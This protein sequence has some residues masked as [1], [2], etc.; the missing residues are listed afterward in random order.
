MDQI[1]I[2]AAVLF[3]GLASGLVGIHIAPSL[4][5]LD[6][7]G[8]RRQHTGHIPRVGGL[9]LC[10]AV[11]LL[12]LF[13]LFRLPLTPLELCAVASMAILGFMDDRLE[14]RARWKAIL[15]LTVALVLAGATLHHLPFPV[16]SLN[17]LGFAVPGHPWV[18]FGLLAVM[19]WCLPHAF[20]LIDGA[21]GLATGFGL[22][23]LCSLWAKG[24]PHPVAVGGLLACLALNWPKAKLF[25]GD[26]GSLSIGL[27][28]VIFAQ[29]ALLMPEPNHIM[30]LFAYPTVDVLTVT[31]IR[32]FSKKPIMQGDRNHLHYQIADRWPALAPTAVPLLLAISA[33]CGSEVYLPAPWVAVP[34]LGLFAL[35][36]LAA[37][38]TVTSVF[39]VAKAEAEV[40][41]EDPRPARA[42]I[43]PD[44]SHLEP[45]LIPRDPRWRNHVTN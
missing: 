39:G 17:L 40:A 37:F 38:F 45:K 42:L 43:D 18:A 4:G 8:G 14:L 27:L 5:L 3:V 31:A 2:T 7:P 25:L 36:G 21:N 26:C 1:T 16:P 35:L 9:A 29:K 11:L 19:F 28:L 10:A 33:M 6:I 12:S 44:G 30:W 32:I 22:V 20:N 24:S 13:P 23:V 41:L 34:Y 15:G